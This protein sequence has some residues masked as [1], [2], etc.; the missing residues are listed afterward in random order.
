MNVFGST[1][2]RIGVAAIALF[3][4][5]TTSTA[6]VTRLEIA[7]RDSAASGQSFG[8]AGPYVNVRGRVHGQLDPRDR[9]NRIIQDLDLAPRNAAGKVEYVATF[10]LMMPAD[11]AKASGVLVYSVVNRG[12]GAATPSPDGHISLVSGWQGDVTPTP[13]NQTIQVPVARNRD[14]SASPGRCWRGSAICRPAPPPRRF[15]SARWAP[16]FYAPATLDTS[17]ATLTFRTA[18]TIAG[19]TSG[20]GTVSAD[21]WAF[22]DCRTAAVSRHAGSVAHLPA[23]T[24]SIRRGSTSSST[25]RRIRSCSASA[26]PRPATSSTSSATPPRI[27]PGPPT[28][29]PAASRTAIAL[30]TSQSGNF[31]KTFVHLGFNED[32]AGTAGV[33]RHPPVHRGPPAGD[34]HPVRLAGRR[35]GPLRAG[36]RAGAVVGQVHRHDA[37][38]D[39]PRACSIGARDTKT[40]PKVIE[41]FGAT[42]FWGLRMSPGLVGTDARPDIALPANVRR[43]YMPG[44]NHGGGRGGFQ[45]G[46][47][48]RRTLQPGRRTPTRWP[49]RIAR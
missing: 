45:I 11:L 9:R 42:E 38:P 6:Q 8:S 19:V 16:R 7:S 33:R 39:E 5:A 15:A 30:G 43:Y 21:R 29:W 4:V 20:E 37:R 31:L 10:S 24:A 44:T 26:S 34:E 22:A 17:R 36:Q 18:E 32:A 25:P 49:T 35:G 23:R 47:A 40:C 27:R 2:G 12:N 14:G 48:D 3:G 46:A 28:R 1:I 41:A 13:N